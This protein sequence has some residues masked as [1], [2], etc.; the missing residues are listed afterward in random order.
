MSQTPAR[1]K[2]GE[3]AMA[4][5]IDDTVATRDGNILRDHDALG[6]AELVRKK[7]VSTSELL[8]LAIAQVEKLNPKLNFLAREHYD[9]ARKAIAKGLP[10]G[11]FTGVPWL[12]KDLNTYVAGEV[13]GQGSSWYQ[14][15]V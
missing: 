14:N 2:T 4:S 10:D 13:T 6:L 8:D 9:R 7:E 5:T 15:N 1:E 11:P 12:L 3:T